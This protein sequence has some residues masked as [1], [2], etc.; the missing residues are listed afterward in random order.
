[1]VTTCRAAAAAAGSVLRLLAAG[2]E[3]LRE[4]GGEVR[5]RFRAGNEPGFCQWT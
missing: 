2:V 5:F 3:D 4:G 1:M